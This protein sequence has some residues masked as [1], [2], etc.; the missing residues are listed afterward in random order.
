MQNDFNFRGL[1]DSYR[2][3]ERE[4]RMHDG[5]FGENYKN[6]G[7]YLKD[8]YT[9]VV[10]IMRGQT[11]HDHASMMKNAQST[12]FQ[13]P[14]PGQHGGKTL[15]HTKPKPKPK[16]IVKTAKK[17]VVSQRKKTWSWSITGSLEAKESNKRSHALKI[18]SQSKLWLSLP[19]S[20]LTHR[21]PRCPPSVPSL[22]RPCCPPETWTQ[23][24][25]GSIPHL[26]HTPS[27][28]IG[29]W[30]LVALF[31]TREKACTDWVPEWTALVVIPTLR[32]VLLRR[33]MTLLRWYEMVM[34]IE[35]SSL[36][37]VSLLGSS[38]YISYEIRLS[39]F[40]TP[41]KFPYYLYNTHSTHRT[42][43]CWVSSWPSKFSACS[44]SSLISHSSSS[45]FWSQCS[46]CTFTTSFSRTSGGFSNH[47]ER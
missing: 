41:S 32:Q 31:E 18:Q 19:L 47:S 14:V 13:P 12:R 24:A 17:P 21:G 7:L 3:I 4:L 11:A 28:R 35:F 44:C 39:T 16:P 29:P 20:I 43:P 2:L 46:G 5:E 42:V 1:G 45:S 10:N 22:L 30:D 25:W 33:M 26:K 40:S 37:L 8:I 27:S 38:W 9:M 36:G 34:L 6:G 23:C 15:A